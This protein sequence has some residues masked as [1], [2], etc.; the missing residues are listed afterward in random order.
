[1]S[2]ILEYLEEELEK[3]WK[4]N[5]DETPGA[6]LVKAILAAILGVV[7]IAFFY[8]AFLSLGDP[9]N[10]PPG[11]CLLTFV[12]PP[13]ALLSLALGLKAYRLAQDRTTPAHWIGRIAV[14][15]GFLV[16][17]AMILFALYFSVIL[18]FVS[19]S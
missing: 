5:P 9:S 13:V 17:I 15:I 7:S 10:M 12:A 6:R 3:V 4:T 8:L 1:M 14:S 11:T 19:V 2:A 16:V 18:F